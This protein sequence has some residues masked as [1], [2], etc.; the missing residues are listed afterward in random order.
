MATQSNPNQHEQRHPAI[1]QKVIEQENQSENQAAKQETADAKPEVI[2]DPFEIR[3]RKFF[4][5]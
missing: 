1:Q 4:G 2:L 3:R 5:K